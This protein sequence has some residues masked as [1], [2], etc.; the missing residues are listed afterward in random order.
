MKVKKWSKNKLG[1]EK[2]IRINVRHNKQL[3]LNGK[4]IESVEEFVY[5]GS[6]LSRSNEKDENT[7]QKIG[8]AKTVIPQLRLIWQS[9]QLRKRTKQNQNL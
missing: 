5:L 8:K 3:E 6:I 9:N 2:E 1:K 7:A 4:V